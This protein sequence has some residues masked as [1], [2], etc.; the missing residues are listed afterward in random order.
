MA[1]TVVK[2]ENILDVIPPELMGAELRLARRQAKFTQAEAAT[3]I[4][5]ARTTLVAIEQGKRRIQAGELIRLAR[6]YGKQVS[7]FVRPRPVI[8]GFGEL[9]AEFVRLHRN[10]IRRMKRRAA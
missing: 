10:Y 7:D 9:Q 1:T 3:F 6:A 2:Q 4:G 8:K 5:A